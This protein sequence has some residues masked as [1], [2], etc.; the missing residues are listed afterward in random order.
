VFRKAL[1]ILLV[2][3]WI[4]LSSIDVLEDLDLGAYP[5]IQTTDT[6]GF[7]HFGRHIQI[8]NNVVENGNRHIVAAAVVLIAATV[9]EN[10][11]FRPWEKQA[12][13]S[14]KNFKIYKLHKAFLI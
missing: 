13:T 9:V 5:K 11:G 2:G 4:V 8:A 12:K 14:Q 3:S 7:P 6:S 10:V 1:A